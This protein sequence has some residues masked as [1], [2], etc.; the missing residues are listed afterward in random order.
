M[1]MIIRWLGW[2][3]PG[4]ST[5]VPIYGL[6]V[7]QATQLQ[8]GPA[9][10]QRQQLMAAFVQEARGVPGEPAQFNSETEVNCFHATLTCLWSDVH[11]GNKN[12]ETL[13]CLTV[14]GVPLPGNPHL[15]QMP[16]QPCGCGTFGGLPSP[17][18]SPRMHHFWECPI[19]QAV[20]K[21][22]DRHLPS[23]ATTEGSMGRH[24]LWLIQAL[25]GCDQ[26]RRM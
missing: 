14:D 13:W 16:T 15:S 19:A 1:A 18:S 5:T 23:S 17:L 4:G 3:L 26:P 11:W 9:Q 6:T 7:R 12:K 10:Q 25:P 8:G 20:R 21:H 2:R 22:I 24:H